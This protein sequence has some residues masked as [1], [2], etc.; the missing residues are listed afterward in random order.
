[1]LKVHFGYLEGEMRYPDNYFRHV[2]MD[3]WFDDDL[4]KQMVLD[5]DK[6]IVYSAYNMKSPVFGACNYSVLSGGVKNLIM[7]YKTDLILDGTNSGDNCAKW[8]IKIGELRD[9]T[10][11]MYHIMDFCPNNVDDPLRIYVMNSGVTTRTFRDYIH[12]ANIYL[13]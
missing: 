8:F 1:M 11:T 10:L 7:A 3:D 4:V 9:I 13:R 12:E 6:T 2:V 5:V